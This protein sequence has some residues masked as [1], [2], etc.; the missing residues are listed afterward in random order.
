MDSPLKYKKNEE[1]NLLSETK[2]EDFACGKTFQNLLNQTKRIV[3]I[4]KLRI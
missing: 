1:L 3:F 4:K 2:I